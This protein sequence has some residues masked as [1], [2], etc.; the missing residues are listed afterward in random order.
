M[1]RGSLHINTTLQGPYGHLLD[2]Y[3][4]VHG[5][6]KGLIFVNGLNLGWYWP[7]KG[8]QNTQFIPGPLLRWGANDIVLLEVE[9]A[10]VL[11]PSGESPLIHLPPSS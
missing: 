2:T 6:N 1:C 3:L 8:P 11:D 10:A 9:P 7:A 5:W 4:D